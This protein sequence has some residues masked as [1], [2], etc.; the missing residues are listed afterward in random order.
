[1]GGIGGGCASKT[2][3]R[4]TLDL[5][6]WALKPFFNDL[7]NAAIAE[8][9]AQHPT[10]RVRWTDIAADAMRRKVFAAGAAETLPDV[11]NFSDQHFAQFAKLDALHELSDIVPGDPAARYIAGALEPCFVDSRLLALPW[12]LSTTVRVMNVPMLADGGLTPDTVGGDWQTLLDQARPFQEKTGKHLFT[13]QLG[14]RSDLLPMMLA[15]GIDLLMPRDKG[16]AVADLTRPQISSFVKTWADAY[17]DGTLPRSCATGGYQAMVLE[18]SEGNVALINANALKSIASD[19]PQIYRQLAVGPGVVGRLGIPGVAVAHMSVTRKS[20][21]PREAAL[22]AW[23]LTNP[24]WQT[25]LALQAGRA[26]STI[27]SLADERWIATTDD[28][29][30]IATEMDISQVS[31]AR[32]F[33]PATGTWPDLR[34]V[35]D[36]AMKR[37]L[38]SDEAVDDALQQVEREWNR[39]L[40]ADAAGEPYA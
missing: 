2:S 5:W 37:V 40:R 38:L 13:L 33:A 17:A 3:G 22:L 7:I 11:I 31:R 39:I 24:Q 36:E 23:H 26:P 8:F 1:M 6:T 27:E 20:Q 25:E 12:Y 15:D 18:M 35:F 14:D 9:E 21:H 10:L 34:R 30:A 19:A 4:V 29:Q 32:A 16:G 28:P